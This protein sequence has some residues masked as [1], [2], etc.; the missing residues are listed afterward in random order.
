MFARHSDKRRGFNLI[1]L[2]VVI[3]IIAILIALLVPA[4]VKVREAAARTHCQNNLKQI[5]IAYNNW[6]TTNPAII[7]KTTGWLAT[8][9]PYWENNASV[10]SC[11]SRVIP[12][13]KKAG[14]EP[15]DYGLNGFVGKRRTFPSTSTTL[16]S[17]EFSDGT[18]IDGA[19]FKFAK[20]AMSSAD[21]LGTVADPNSKTPSG[22]QPRH[23]IG[24]LMNVLFMDG[25]VEIHPYAKYNPDGGKGPSCATS[26]HVD[27]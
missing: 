19:P 2:L 3:A 7:F 12:A 27:N 23:P 22:V 14:V 1:Q 24:V 6:R 8:L 21:Y 10:T 20:T 9:S 18:V 26:W 13:V 16:L 15:S 25:H 17:I 11:P 4:V 5:G